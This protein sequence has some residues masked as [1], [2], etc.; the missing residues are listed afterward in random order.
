M[1]I[2]IKKYSFMLNLIVATIVLFTFISSTHATDV[3]N[4]L[5]FVN[6]NTESDSALPL[7]ANTLAY[8]EDVDGDR[9]VDI[10]IGAEVQDDMEF[11][12]QEISS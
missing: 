8:I 3:P 1:K 11:Y 5:W 10:V 2:S 7:R 9:I 6:I 4:M 12:N